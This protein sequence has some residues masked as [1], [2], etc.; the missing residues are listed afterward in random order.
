MSAATRP[1]DRDA[2]RRI[3]RA[4][5]P[6]SRVG[7]RWDYHYTRMKLASDPLYP[8]VADALR[9]TTAPLLDLGCGLGLLA[10]TLRAARLAM[11]YRGVD[12]DARKT[13]KAAR[14]AALAGLDDVAFETVDLTRTMPA[15]SGSVAILDVL[16]Y[17]DGDAQAAILDAA[18][19]MLAPGGRLV[20]RTGLDVGSRR[21]RVTHAADA[22]GRMVGWMYSRP[23][24]Y[25]SE[26]MLRA[27]LGAAGLHCDFLPLYGDTPFN[28]WRIV[29]QRDG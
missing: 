9:G 13:A 22:F 7:S 24:R 15:H 6:S 10:H 21:L 1:L 26:A 4:F 25:P 3:A 12:V 11:P 23:R 29:A 14:V 17:V 20:I 8:G 19:A 18:A 27:R 5:L 2:A 28:N 16:Q